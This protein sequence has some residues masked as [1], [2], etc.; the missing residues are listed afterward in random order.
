M[1][2]YGLW[3]KIAELVRRDGG[4]RLDEL[5]E[6]TGESM[7]TVKSAAWGM[8]RTGRLDY[9][10]GWFTL[11]APANSG[12]GKRSSSQNKPSPLRQAS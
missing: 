9:C 6:L 4:L 11:P 8:C 12:M 3:G 7:A 2:G 5:A 1:G 10:A